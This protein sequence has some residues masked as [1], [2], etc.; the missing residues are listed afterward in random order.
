MASCTY[1]PHEHVRGLGVVELKVPKVVVCRLGLGHLVVGLGL[2]GMND[3]GELDG[4]LDE[5]DGDIVA[6][7]VPVALL[8][9]E[10]DSEAADIAYCVGAATAAEDGR[11]ANED[12]CLA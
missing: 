9:V 1:T 6:D 12:G 2:A 10:L 3:I 4:V 7:N 8:R 11:E 5:E